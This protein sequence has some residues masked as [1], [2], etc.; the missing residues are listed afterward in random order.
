MKILREPIHFS[1][2]FKHNNEYSVDLK[3]IPFFKIMASVVFYR[4]TF[5]I[6]QK[7][8]HFQC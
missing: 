2:F 8:Q 4:P 3:T 1:P 6:L 5:D 7:D